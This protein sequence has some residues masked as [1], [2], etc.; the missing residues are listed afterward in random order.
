MLLVSCR[1]PVKGN[2]E[3]SVVN[4][5]ANSRSKALSRKSTRRKGTQIVNGNRRLWDSGP[6]NTDPTRVHAV[7]PL[8]FDTVILGLGE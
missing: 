4:L 2:N 8:G 6:K 3:I 1:N 7:L 5:P